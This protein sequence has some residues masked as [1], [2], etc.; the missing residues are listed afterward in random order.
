MSTTGSKKGDGGPRE[1]PSGRAGVREEAKRRTRQALMDAATALIAEQ[2]LD[3]P[4]LDAI[5]ERAG[6]TRGALYVHFA[7]REALVE[8]VMERA[9]EELLG[10]LLPQGGDL[11][12]AV[13]RFVGAVMSGTYPLASAG[14]IKPH[15]L[16]A[17]CAR[18]PRLRAWYQRATAASVERLAEALGRS[19]QQ[20]V[21]R[22]DLSPEVVAPILLA[23]VLGAQTML[24]LGIPLSMGQSALA[25]LRMLGP[26][27]APR[28]ARRRKSSRS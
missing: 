15:Q 5:C 13:A 17:A 28:A 9:G 2:G 1:G 10:T 11:G 16:Y 20:G 25:L 4:S 6:Y 26:E 27:D 7:D 12:G 19:Q 23:V 18:S 22:D 21:L 8:A 14:G 3:G 24:E